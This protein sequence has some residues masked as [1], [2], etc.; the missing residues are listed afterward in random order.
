MPLCD[1]ALYG[2]LL[3]ESTYVSGAR[4]RKWKV[5]P[6]SVVVVTACGGALAVTTTP[7]IGACVSSST[8]LPET[9]PVVPAI[10][11]NGRNAA[12]RSAA[13]I[14]FNQR[15]S[16]SMAKPTAC[17]LRF[18]DP[19]SRE[20]KPEREP[21]ILSVPCEGPADG[22]IGGPLLSGEAEI[23]WARPGV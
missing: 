23:R 11:S 18:F 4:E 12:T 21:C 13:K 5:P 6:A 14:D 9:A 17:P 10:T 3:N 22:R 1:S 8:T 16:E 20:E 15:I 2:G 19:V 7:A